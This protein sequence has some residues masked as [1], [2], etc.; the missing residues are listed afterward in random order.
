M[1]VMSTLIGLGKGS[2]LKLFVLCY[3]II[4]FGV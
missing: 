2:G 3:Y 4:A 1:V